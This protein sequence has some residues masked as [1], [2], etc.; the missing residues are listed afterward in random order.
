MVVLFENNA[1]FPA[2]V[3]T[4][5]AYWED[6]ALPDMPVLADTGRAILDSTPWEADSLPGKCV[7]TPEMEILTCYTGHGNDQALTAILDH[8][9]G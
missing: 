6:L 7:L 8:W 4:A 5:V 1:G 2:T 9:G 3:E